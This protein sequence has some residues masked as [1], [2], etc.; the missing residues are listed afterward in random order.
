VF[1]APDSFQPELASRFFE[2]ALELE[3]ENVDVMDEYADMLLGVGNVAKASKLLR[4]SISLAPDAGYSKFMNLGQVMEGRD[5]VQCFEQGVVNMQRVLQTLQDAKEQA[6][7][8]R[9]MSNGFLSIAELWMTDLCF[10]ANAE[11]SCESAV[12]RAIAADATNPDALQVG[13]N[14]QIRLQLL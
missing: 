1:V 8:R 9:E 6:T 12:Q 13:N 3:P 5:A 10:E 7:L 11:Q 4:K 2:R 14:K